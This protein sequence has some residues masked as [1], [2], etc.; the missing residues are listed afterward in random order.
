MLGQTVKRCEF[1]LFDSDPDNVLY[2]IRAFSSR[3]VFSQDHTAE[4]TVPA[5]ESM[6]AV[7]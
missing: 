2:P 4:A 1:T 7:S 3:V 6:R 5:N